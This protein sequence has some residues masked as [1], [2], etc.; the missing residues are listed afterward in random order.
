MA[1]Y[2]LRRAVVSTAFVTLLGAGCGDD[3]TGTRGDNPALDLV[4]T[5]VYISEPAL[6]HS[7]QVYGIRI[8]AEW[9]VELLAVEWSTGRIVDAVE[10]LR[11]RIVN[12]TSSELTLEHEAMGP[13]VPPGTIYTKT[14]T[15]EATETTLRFVGEV[16]TSNIPTNVTYHRIDIGEQVVEPVV[17]TLRVHVSGDEGEYLFVSDDIAL[18]PSAISYAIPRQYEPLEILSMYGINREIGSV[19]INLDNPAGVGTYVIDGEHHYAAMF[20]PPDPMSDVGP[21]GL[22]AVGGTVTI[23][24]FDRANH[25]CAR[26]FQLDLE[27]YQGERKTLTGGTFDLYM[28]VPDE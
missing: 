28:Y 1:S 9:S 16:L 21:P 11:T 14:Y 18:L 15:Y 4:G 27:N 6:P 24:V 13:W 22:G 19:S 23:D 8:T 10:D 25:R 5:W 20:D 3:G 2:R 17:S 26:T 12:P 7:R